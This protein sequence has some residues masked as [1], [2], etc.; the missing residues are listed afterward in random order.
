MGTG[1]ASYL[2]PGST[3]INKKIELEQ[4]NIGIVPF[5]M[6]WHVNCC[7]TVQR[8]HHGVKSFGSGVGGS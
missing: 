6:K 2:T 4:W 3:P 1:R 7:E 5:K 8:L